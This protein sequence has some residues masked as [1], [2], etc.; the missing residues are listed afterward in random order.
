MAKDD[1]G[2]VRDLGDDENGKSVAAVQK[3]A[4]GGVELAGLQSLSHLS[5]LPPV[6]TLTPRS[7]P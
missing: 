4:T 3:G 5:G 1:D 2:I 7:P 6:L